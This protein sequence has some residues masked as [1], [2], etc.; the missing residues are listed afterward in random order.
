MVVAVVCMMSTEK[1]ECGWRILTS[2]YKATFTQLT[3]NMW[4]WMILYYVYALS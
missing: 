1:G 2:L 3:S 4:M